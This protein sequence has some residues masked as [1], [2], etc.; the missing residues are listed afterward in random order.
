M[1]SP[2]RYVYMLNRCIRWPFRRICPRRLFHNLPYRD[3]CWSGRNSFAD[4]AALQIRGL[5]ELA[6]AKGYLVVIRCAGSS[7]WHVL[8][9][10]GKSLNEIENSRLAGLV[11]RIHT[12]HPDIGYRRIRDEL[13]ARCREHVNDK[14]I[15]RICRMKKIQSSIKWK[16]RC[17]TRASKDA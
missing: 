6:E 12:E 16:P 1:P 2:H 13:N 3:G 11:E 17:C 9:I 7:E 8:H 5:K 14:R 4:A 10:T 15:L